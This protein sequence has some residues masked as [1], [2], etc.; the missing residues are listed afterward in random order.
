MSRFTNYEFL[1]DSVLLTSV[2]GVV[3]S[4]GKRN[5]GATFEYWSIKP[6]GVALIQRKTIWTKDITGTD[7][8]ITFSSIVPD[9]EGG[10]YTAMVKSGFRVNDG[11]NGSS[12]IGE[13]YSPDSCWVAQMDADLKVKRIFASDKQSYAA[14]QYRAMM[15][16]TVLGTEDGTVYAFSNAM[17]AKTKHKAS[18]LRI[19]KG[20]NHF[21]PDYF[22]DIQTASGGYKFRR[23][24]YAGEHRFLLEL[25]ND[26]NVNVM[27][28]GH[29]FAVVDMKAKTFSRVAGLPPKAF[30]VSGAESGGVP[31]YYQGAIYLPISLNGENAQLYKIDPATA[32]SKAIATFVGAKEL[33]SIGVLH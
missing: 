13:V 30:I 31:C 26:I 4:D 6:T 9:G 12:S 5:D 16:R 32:Q 3:S 14:G 27:S 11:T 33:R 21:D 20:V 17:H 10:F 28:P 23:I 19:N 29:D 18:A 7:E 1:N 15:L 8:Q 24:W 25:Y 2:S 22:F